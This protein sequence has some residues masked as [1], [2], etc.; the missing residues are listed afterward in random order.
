MFWSARPEEV[1]M[2]QVNH[3]PNTDTCPK[4]YPYTDASG[5]AAF[6]IVYSTG[7]RF[8][9]RPSGGDDRSWL[10]DSLGAGEVM[11]PAPGKNWFPSTPTNFEQSP[12]TQ[13]RRFSNTAAPIILYR[14]TELIKAV[15][16]GRMIYLAADEDEVEFIRSFGF[17]ATCCASGVENWR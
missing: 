13:E 7:G 15:A 12:P 11:R 4:I 8:V 3:S 9:R 5:Q 10:W 16:A 17:V 14:H 6:Q 1:G 2:T